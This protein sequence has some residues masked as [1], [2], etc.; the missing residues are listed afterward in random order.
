MAL[1]SCKECN[2]EISDKAAVCPKCG[3]PVEVTGLQAGPVVITEQT[4]KKYKALQLA[5]VI[6]ILA[7]VVSCAGHDPKSASWLFLFGLVLY[8]WARVGAWW[9]HG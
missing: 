2:T 5:G 9:N 7:G 8:V 4:G 6:M 1:I 3:A